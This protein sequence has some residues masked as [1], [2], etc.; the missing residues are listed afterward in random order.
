MSANRRPPGRGPPCL[1]L[2]IHRGALCGLPARRHP[3]NRSVHLW[4]PNPAHY[5]ILTGKDRDRLAFGDGDRGRK[6]GRRKADTHW[7]D[8]PGVEILTR[9]A[10]H[11][12]RAAAAG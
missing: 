1:I 9:R 4:S 6:E 11:P 2:G 12:G 10:T 7:E 8:L 5:P 3:R